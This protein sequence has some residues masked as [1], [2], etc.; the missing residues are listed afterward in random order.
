[1]RRIVLT[2]L[3]AVVLAC[4]KAEEPFTIKNACAGIWL[5]V[6]DGSHRV[7]VDHLE[8][9]KF[10]YPDIEGYRG[11]TV[12]LV[13]SGYEVGSNRDMGTEETSRDIPYLKSNTYTGPDQIRPWTVAH[14]SSPGIPNG[15]CKN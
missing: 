6:V 14:L 11:S 5:K 4:S 7:L 2:T 13:A 3:L 15:G 9:G 8:A 1:M 12:Y 10:A